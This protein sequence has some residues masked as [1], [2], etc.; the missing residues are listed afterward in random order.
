MGYC[1]LSK[2][3]FRKYYKICLKRLFEM[4][5]LVFGMFHYKVNWLSGL[6]LLLRSTKKI[7]GRLH[8][9]PI[10]IEIYVREMKVGRARLT[11]LSFI[12]FDS[13]FF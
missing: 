12:D 9:Q 7:M 8:S 13:L 11:L 1:I 6:I 10:T 3:G 2:P 4:K 5:L